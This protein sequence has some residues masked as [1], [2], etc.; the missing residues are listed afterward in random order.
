MNTVK[1]IIN[2]D[3][4]PSIEPTPTILERLYLLIQHLVERVFSLFRNAPVIDREAQTPKVPTLYERSI[5]FASDHKIAIGICAAVAFVGVCY[6]ATQYASSPI[7]NI[8]NM[9]N[10]PPTPTPTPTQ[11]PTSFPKSGLTNWLNE[12]TTTQTGNADSKITFFT[13]YTRDNPDRLTLSREVAKVHQE[14]CEEKG[15]HH[16]L[17][18]RNLAQDPSG[19]TVLP[20]WS[21]IAGLK[22]MLNAEHYA[23]KEWFVWLDDDMVITNHEIQMESL[24]EKLAPS[25]HIIVTEDA[26]SQI[27]PNIPLNT[28]FIL[29]KNSD[30]SRK[31]IDRLWNMRFDSITSNY[32]YAD[33]PNQSCLHEQQA[34]TDLLKKPGRIP[35]LVRVIEQRFLDGIGINTFSRSSH[36]DSVRQLVLHYNDPDHSKWQPG[37]FMAQCTGLATEGKFY[38]PEKN[39][40]E[41]ENSN[42]RERCIH[43]LIGKKPITT[44]FSSQGI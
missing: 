4:T 26:V 28:G 13:S 32:S 17:F 16:L 23:A 6:L 44:L 37:D 10:S 3:I 22:E 36:F 5:T 21:K 34:L 30:I 27:F 2:K 33:C 25:D 43:A 19:K 31:I 40:Y 9:S 39:L 12:E 7:G 14:Y 41:Q 38:I 20:Y 8:P 42:L 15:Y 35:N 18:E 1:N 24:I 11:A 29:V